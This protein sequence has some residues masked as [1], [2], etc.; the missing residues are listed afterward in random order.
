ML[1]IGRVGTEFSSMRPE[2]QRHAAAYI[3]INEIALTPLRL[4]RL[5]STMAQQVAST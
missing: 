5:R 2:V 1:Q 4:F 3:T